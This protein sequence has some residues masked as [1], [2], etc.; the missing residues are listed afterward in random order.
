MDKPWDLVIGNRRKACD[1]QGPEAWIRSDSKMICGKAS[2]F[3]KSFRCSGYYA[4]GGHEEEKNR[5]QEM[6]VSGALRMF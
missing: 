1:L 2:V 6:C 4:E 3:W 5:Q